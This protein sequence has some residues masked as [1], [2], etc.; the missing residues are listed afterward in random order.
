MEAMLEASRF[1]GVPEI[2][3]LHSKRGVNYADFKR[4]TLKLRPTR[5]LADIAT[6][7]AMILLA[8]FLLSFIATNSPF[9]LLAPLF[10]LWIGFW[11]QAYTIYFHEAAHYN[12][13]PKKEINDLLSDVCLTPFVGMWI[14][15]YRVSHWKHHLYLGTRDD[16]EISYYKPVG[17][18]QTMEVLTGLYLLKAAYKYLTNF[19]RAEA[20]AQE[21]SVRLQFFIALT[22][23]FAS[24]AAIIGLLFWYV[25]FAA[26]L[27]WALAFLVFLPFF[28]RLRQTLEHRSFTADRY[29]DYTKVEHGPVNRIFGSDFLSKHFGGA[30]FNRH[31]LHH[32][33]PTVS[34]TSFDELE[35]FFLDTELA[36]QIEASRTTYPKAFGILLR[37]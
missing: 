13:H 3:N 1:S 11:L 17:V 21:R 35:R 16:T 33:D 18:G 2:R 32:Y 12:I 24:Q 29:T 7:W 15:L 22:I 37:Q 10:G 26:S 27:S 23:M 20:V 4:D 25:S 5:I 8:L 9:V 28:H 30:G 6:A 19:T 36:P 14:R 31:L 34:Y